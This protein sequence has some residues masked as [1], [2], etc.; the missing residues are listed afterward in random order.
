MHY[1]KYH[2]NGSREDIRYGDCRPTY[3][4]YYRYDSD[5]QLNMNKT[6]L[7]SPPPPPSSSAINNNDVSDMCCTNH[8]YTKPMPIQQ[9]G[10]RRDPTMNCAYEAVNMRKSAS[11][12]P[13]S[14]QYRNQVVHSTT[15]FLL[16]VLPFFLLLFPNKSVTLGL[17]MCACDNWPPQFY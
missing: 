6:K 4:D 1:P 8:F 16:F 12:A 15:N 11:P 2:G 13:P 9:C 10:C 3:D 14:W 7:M 17:F 5:G